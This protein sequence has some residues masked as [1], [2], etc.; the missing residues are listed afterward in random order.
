M[1]ILRVGD[2]HVRVSNIDESDELLAFIADLAIKNQVDRIEILGDLFHTHAIL[3]LEVLE[4]W[5]NALEHLSDICEVVVLIGNHDQTGDYN[6]HSSALD[7]FSKLKL[8]NLKIME[9]PQAI[10]PIGYVSYIHDPVKFVETANRVYDAGARVLVCHQTFNGSKFES[11]MYAPDGIDPDLLKFELIISGHIHAQQRFGKVIYPGT[12]RWDTASDAN[13]VKGLWIF[14]HCDIT[15]AV[16]KETFIS[17]ET[18]C[19]P[20]ISFTFKEGDAGIPA[21]PAGARVSVELIGSSVWCAQEKEKLKGKCS[22]KT[23]ITDRKQAT[24]RSAGD[25]FE[26]FMNNLFVTAMD[27]PTLLKYAKELGIV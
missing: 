17:T 25:S 13:Q 22:V 15:G 2:P 9:Y 11:G 12:A 1:K 4:F 26:Q 7:I 20:L 24:T 6:S 14:E 3:R 16:V 8:K 18:V 5:T 21:W 27:R 23:K 19:K 10:G